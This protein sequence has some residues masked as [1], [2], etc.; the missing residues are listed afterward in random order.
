M[1]CGCRASSD[2]AAGIRFFEHLRLPLPR[3]LGTKPS[4]KVLIAIVSDIFLFTPSPPD[5]QKIFGTMPF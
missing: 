4:K 5:F 1:G 3:A 2:E